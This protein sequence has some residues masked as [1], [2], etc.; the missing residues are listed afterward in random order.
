VRYKIDN[1]I[2]DF[3]RITDDLRRDENIESEKN[4]YKKNSG[5]EY[6]F[7]Y[8]FYYFFLEINNTSQ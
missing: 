4:E 3:K 2:A 7:F 8:F 1:K 5:R 6:L